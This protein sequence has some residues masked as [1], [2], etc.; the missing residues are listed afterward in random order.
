MQV[1][2]APVEAEE[3]PKPKYRV[4]RGSG[5]PIYLLTPDHKKHWILNAETFT[6]LGFKFGDE[7]KIENSELATY[8]PGEP[9][10]LTNWEQYK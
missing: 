10:T 2:A 1:E 8:I 7:E 4:V 6:K 5:D 9:I 3:Q